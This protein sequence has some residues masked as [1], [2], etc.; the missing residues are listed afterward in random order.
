MYLVMIDSYARSLYDY[1]EGAYLFQILHIIDVFKCIYLQT[2]HSFGD[3]QTPESLIIQ[4][5]DANLD[6]SVRSVWMTFRN[7]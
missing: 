5:Y 3:F 7:I 6:T 1:M 2:P 4:G